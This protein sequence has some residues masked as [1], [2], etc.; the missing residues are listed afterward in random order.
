MLN[1]IKNRMIFK[2]IY[3]YT[4][5][6]AFHKCTKK[7]CKKSVPRFSSNMQEVF[8]VDCF[9]FILTNKE[10]KE[11]YE[12]LIRGM[13]NY[14]FVCSKWNGHKF[15]GEQRSIISF[16]DFYNY[17]I[18]LRHY[19]GEYN[20]DFGTLND[21]IFN[22]YFRLEYIKIF[23]KRKYDK[24]LKLVYNKQ[25]I[26]EFDRIL[27]LKKIVD[28]SCKEETDHN[29]GIDIV[30]LMKELYTVKIFGH[31]MFDKIECKLELQLKSFVENKDIS[32]DGNRYIALGKSLI[33]IYN[34]ENIEK[35]HKD[36]I[37]IQ[38]KLMW[39]TLMATLVAFVQIFK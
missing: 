35:K 13:N 9:V 4:V 12:Y 26:S 16:D 15:D 23:F 21:F 17:N 20:I 39:L 37:L 11:N 24:F 32:C 7:I 38:K 28:M 31:P 10:N 30:S 6:N 27:V 34:Y 22:Y 29:N 36:N 25:K 19:Y 3:N 18:E 14:D 33:T 2:K 1:G 8:E 5:K